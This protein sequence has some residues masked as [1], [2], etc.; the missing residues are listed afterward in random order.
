MRKGVQKMRKIKSFMA[1]LMALVIAV[2][3]INIPAVTAFAQDDDGTAE[4]AEAT[5]SDAEKVSE[6]TT[7]VVISTDGEEKILRFTPKESGVYEFYSICNSDTYGTI[8]DADGEI[9]KDDD[10]S[11]S[12]GNF[13]ITYNLTAGTTYLVG[14]RYLEDDTGTIKLYIGKVKAPDDIRF[15][16]TRTNFLTRIDYNYISNGNIEVEYADGRDTSNTSITVSGDTIIINGAF[17]YRLCV[18]D[19]KGNYTYGIDEEQYSYSEVLDLE[20]SL[21]E[22]TYTFEI[23]DKSS[24]GV[25]TSDA[26][27]YDT[28]QIHVLSADD[29]FAGKTEISESEE[30]EFTFH[31]KYYE[32][33]KFTP[34]E[35]AEYLFMS[36]DSSYMEVYDDSYDHI[37]TNNN[38]SYSFTKGTDYYVGAEVSGSDK[39]VKMKAIRYS[40]PTRVDVNVD[41][42]YMVFGDWDSD[43]YLLSGVS[44][45]ITYADGTSEIIEN[46][47][48]DSFVD[49]KGLTYYNYFTKSSDEWN[50]EKYDN[51]EQ[52]S[53]G[54]YVYSVGFGEYDSKRLFSKNI[55]L[56]RPDEYE[57]PELKEGLNTIVSGAD[58]EHSNLYYFVMPFDG[59]LSISESSRYRIYEAGKDGYIDK[60]YHSYSSNLFNLKKGKKY[61]V[62]F[63]GGPLDDDDSAIDVDSWQADVKFLPAVSKI[64]ATAGKKEFIKGVDSCYIKDTILSIVYSDGSEE[65]ILCDEDRDVDTKYGQS[66]RFEYKQNNNT[67]RYEDEAADG[68]FTV[69]ITGSDFDSTDLYDIQVYYLKALTKGNLK[70]GANSITQ[71]TGSTMPTFFKFVPSSS[72]VYSFGACETNVIYHEY[73]DWM[74]DAED[75]QYQV[76]RIYTKENEYDRKASLKAGEAYYIEVS[77]GAKD[78]WGDVQYSWNMNISKVED[79]IG[80]KSWKIENKPMNMK[81]PSGIHADDLGRMFGDIQLDITYSDDSSDNIIWNGGHVEDSKGNEISASVYKKDS[82]NNYEYYAD[83]AYPDSLENGSY[84]LRFRF[85]NNSLDVDYIDIPFEVSDLTN[86]VDGTWNVTEPIKVSN[87]KALYIY[88]LDT[89]NVD[90][91]TFES[92]VSGVSLTLV[93]GK[94]NPL[95]LIAD[96]D[97]TYIY[98]NSWSTDK[99]TGDAYLYICPSSDHAATK[100]TAHESPEATSISVSTEKKNYYIGYGEITNNDQL[101]EREVKVSI[102]YSDGKIRD[103][104]GNNDN[105]KLN[106]TYIH[107]SGS[108]DLDEFIDEGTY[109]IGATTLNMSKNC[110]VTRTTVT[111]KK[112]DVQTLQAVE[113]GKTYKL[114][115]KQDND[116][117]MYYRFDA[118]ETGT[119]SV[120][121]GISINMIG[122]YNVDGD[123]LSSSDDFRYK[124]LRG[125]TYVIKIELSAD[126][127]QDFKLTYTDYEH[128]RGGS[129]TLGE[130]KAIKITVGGK[131]TDYTFCPTTS[132]SYI[133]SLSKGEYRNIELYQGDKYIS[134]STYDYYNDVCKL[135]AYLSKGITYTYVIPTNGSED[136]TIAV[137][138]EKGGENPTIAAAEVVKDS[139]EYIDNAHITGMVEL[140]YSDGSKNDLNFSYWINEKCICTD[141][142]DNSVQI[143]F[144][145]L[146]SEKNPE[147]MAEVRYKSYDSNEWKYVKQKTFNIRGNYSDDWENANWIKTLNLNEDYKGNFDAQDSVY[148]KFK[149][150]AS[151]KYIVKFTGANITVKDLDTDSVIGYEGNYIYNLRA[152][153]TYGI[154][155]RKY[156]GADGGYTVCVSSA[157]E[158]EDVTILRYVGSIYYIGYNNYTYRNAKVKVLYAD[159]T[160]ETVNGGETTKDGQYVNCEW[161]EVNSQSAALTVSIGGMSDR[162][163]VAYSSLDTAPELIFTGNIAEISKDFAD[164]SYERAVYKVTVP[165]TGEYASSRTGYTSNTLYNADGTEVSRNENS[166]YSLKKGEVYYLCVSFYKDETVKFGVAYDGTWETIR[167]ATC[168]E[169]GKKRRKNLITGEYEE[170]SIPKIDHKYTKW[171]VTVPATTNTAGKKELVCEMCKLE[172]G[173]TQTI[174]KLKT[175]TLNTKSFVYDGRENKPSVTVKDDKGKTVNNKNYTVTYKNNKA[176]GKA[177]VTVTFKGD[178]SGKVDL[179]FT[180][181]PAATSIKTVQNTANGVKLTWTK[182]N[183]AGG[184]IVYRKAGKGKYSKLAD[185]NK[186][187]I[188]SYTDKS[189][190][191]GTVYTYKVVA[192]KTAGNTSY[193]AADSNQKSVMRITSS[194]VTKTTNKAGKKM[195]VK[196]S[197]NSK[198]GGYQIQYSVKS[199]FAKAKTVKVTG[200]KKSNVTIAKLAKKK[201]YVRVRSFKKVGKTTYYS[202]W[203]TTKKVVIKK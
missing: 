99:L 77:Q 153:H 101:E 123:Y 172:S 133:L 145:L 48:N 24:A 72:G 33:Y 32:Y 49:S 21:Q 160:S 137:K 148:F 98:G 20:A 106:M 7:D 35:T 197:V 103:F 76:D 97:D 75:E 117:Y 194:K 68:K 90:A 129:L 150:D 182:S 92:N 179:T 180:I 193:N 34:S 159:G 116:C 191:N 89:N 185:I 175:V 189:A 25:P 138:L 184:Y 151:G 54:S 36:D 118:T 63:Y 53:A 80:V 65:D 1:M 136:D 122:M 26:H 69:Y 164:D 166:R 144:T 124:V 16:Q 73:F 70:L 169:T 41:S 119:L 187:T 5:A 149:A 91:L 141:K 29:Y 104:S 146:D 174:A 28:C 110:K 201:Y 127:S 109:S 10:D 61:F 79:E 112:F 115:N 6:G 192:R 165:Q 107:N 176:I 11:G 181:R 64:T 202:A 62:A 132:G 147:V 81:F 183:G 57:W 74:T 22:G 51:Y 163:I 95:P 18:K 156:D 37:E 47:N 87:K 17:T 121:S 60:H 55:T 84:L 120:D 9:I 173:K 4:V 190:K 8:Y 12:G 130:A 23:V 50:S 139:C 140:T 102:T 152:D 200:A 199:N 82:E 105:V 40:E 42:E 14:V 195:T 154:N 108:V 71:I 66:L 126:S 39:T 168:I 157:K 142:Y 52:Y 158:I 56:K 44:A 100:I 46:I 86:L 143:V 30:R 111:V 203:S 135:P 188:L 155:V 113:S 114:E 170:K 161:R 31:S 83:T 58:L 85:S 198:A 177:N 67:Y 19:S 196:W 128:E 178:Y 13:K 27:I 134:G 88:K 94:G 162:Y 78:R 59:S 43:F 2:T 93:D 45:K 38:G 96:Y 15:K 186:N 3:S 167:E 125:N 131:K 171:V